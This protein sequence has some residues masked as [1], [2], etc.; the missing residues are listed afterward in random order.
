MTKLYSIH[1]IP[2]KEWIIAIRP[3]RG[4][5]GQLLFY[6]FFCSQHVRHLQDFVYSGKLS[7]LFSTIFYAVV[8]INE[9]LIIFFFFY[10]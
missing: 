10:R 1:C 3:F 7:L 4:K 5:V 8:P 9:S 2:F 6:S